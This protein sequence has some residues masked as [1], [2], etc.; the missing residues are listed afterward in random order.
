MIVLFTEIIYVFGHFVFYSCWIRF[1]FKYGRFKIDI[2]FIL[3]HGHGTILCN[4]IWFIWVLVICCSSWR[5]DYL[6]HISRHVHAMSRY[7]FKYFRLFCSFRLIVKWFHHFFLIFC[8]Y[9]PVKF[10]IAITCLHI[11]ILSELIVFIPSLDLIFNII[12]YI[13]NKIP[14]I[15]QIPIAFCFLTTFLIFNFEASVPIH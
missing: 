15:A 12:P 6:C 14:K 5:S 13:A 11:S 9:L 10:S 7:F 8:S 3:A 4:F 1:E 2:Q